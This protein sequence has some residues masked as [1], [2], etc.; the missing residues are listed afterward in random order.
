[1][2]VQSLLVVL[3][4]KSSRLAIHAFFTSNMSYITCLWQWH[5]WGQTYTCIGPM[6]C[7]IMSY[8][9]FYWKCHKNDIKNQWSFNWINIIQLACCGLQTTNDRRR[10]EV[11]WI[12][13]RHKVKFSILH[14]CTALDL[15][16]VGFSPDCWYSLPLQIWKWVDKFILSKHCKNLSKHFPISLSLILLYKI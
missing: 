8:E 13:F 3:S 14:W 9:E 15:V 7:N 1:M 2:N 16:D 4:I 11:R 5:G 10:Q 12:F 6:Q